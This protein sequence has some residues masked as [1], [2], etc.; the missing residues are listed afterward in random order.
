MVLTMGTAD[1]RRPTPTWGNEDPKNGGQER[2]AQ[3]G[4]AAGKRWRVEVKGDELKIG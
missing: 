2:N 1:G 3:G 4:E